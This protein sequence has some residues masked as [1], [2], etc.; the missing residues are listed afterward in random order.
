MNGHH[1]ARL[2]ACV[3]GLV[4]DDLLLQLDYLA[5]S[6]PLLSVAKPLPGRTFIAS[7]V[8]VIPGMDF[9]TVEVLTWRGLVTY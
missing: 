6:R 1:W 2:L 5:A 7:H 4:N 3:S 8:A 9:F